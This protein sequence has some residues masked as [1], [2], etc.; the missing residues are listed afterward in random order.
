M[1]I[2][3]LDLGIKSMG[4]CI[5]DEL[6][7]I[8]IPLKNFFFEERNFDEAIN[9]LK[10]ITKKYKIGTIL[11]GYPLKVGGQKSEITLI[12]EEFYKN[13]KKE[14]I[15][16][17]IKLYDERFTTQRG[18]ELLKQKYKDSN[19][20]ALY[21]DMAAAYVMLFDYLTYNNGEHND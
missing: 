13:L 9:I 7:I 21:K 10:D 2:L 18:I 3:S 4:I 1:R 5:T 20:V 17:K 12:V 15:N 14:F 16:I 19:K 11:L 6:N 8:A